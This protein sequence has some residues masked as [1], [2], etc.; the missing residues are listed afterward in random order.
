MQAPRVMV[1]HN[2]S[3]DVVLSSYYDIDHTEDIRALPTIRTPKDSSHLFK[4]AIREFEGD[5]TY[6]YN[7][8][9]MNYN[10]CPNFMKCNF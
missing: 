10:G 7:I 4:H 9:G 2:P 1:Q 8:L 6:R 3:A 5:S